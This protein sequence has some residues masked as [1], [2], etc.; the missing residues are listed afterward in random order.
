MKTF[1]QIAVLF[2]S[3][4]L[5]AAC[6]SAGKQD[7]F[8]RR[9]IYLTQEDYMEDMKNE[10]VQERRTAQPLVESE[11]IF[12][13]IPE[14]DK[15]VYF[16]DERRQPKIP[17]QPSEADYKREKRLWTKPKRYTPEEYYGMQGDNSSGSSSEQPSYDY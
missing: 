10:T 12:N 7:D 2:L 4:G 13:A 5:L 16:F 9:K 6:S 14:T 15:G 17:G 8:N 1:A 11:Y 3:A